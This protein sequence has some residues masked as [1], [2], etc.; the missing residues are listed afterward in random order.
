M[1]EFIIG[2]VENVLGHVTIQNLEGSRV[3]RVPTSGSWR[4]ASCRISRCE[5]TLLGSSEF[6]VLFPQIALED[7]G[8]GQ[9][10][11]NGGIAFPY[12]SAK[13]VIRFRLRGQQCGRRNQ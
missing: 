6:P 4:G 5:I 11:K 10:P 12:F 1:A 2:I 9:E 3:I 8:G 13:I 7:F